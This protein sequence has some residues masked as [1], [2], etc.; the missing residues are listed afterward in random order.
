V[1][2]LLAT[3]CSSAFHLSRGLVIVYGFRLFFFPGD[4]KMADGSQGILLVGVPLLP[5]PR[6]VDFA[7]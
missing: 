1:V 2:V 3:N 5:R 6:T 7:S 4:D